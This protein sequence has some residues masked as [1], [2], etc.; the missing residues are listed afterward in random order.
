[1]YA[2]K[3]TNS[4]Q[5]TIEETERRREIQ[6]KFNKENGLKPKPL[7]KSTESDF[8]QNLNPYKI[9]KVDTKPLINLSSLEELK[10]MI[11]NTKRQMNKMAKNLNFIEAARLRDEIKELEK[12]LQKKK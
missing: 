10:K 9:K 5:K 6:K 2:N 1:M 7:I 8:M 4:M 11:K 12:Y 3:I